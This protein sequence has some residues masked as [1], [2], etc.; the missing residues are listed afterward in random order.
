MIN[1]FVL[2]SKGNF[3][4]LILYLKNNYRFKMLIL[5]VQNMIIKCILN[6]KVNIFKIFYVVIKFMICSLEVNVL[7]ESVLCC[8]RY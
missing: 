6:I 5:N 4:K 7:I 1:L 3:Q 8:Y 2:C